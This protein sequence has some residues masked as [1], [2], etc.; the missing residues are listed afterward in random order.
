M[1]A[2]RLLLLS[3]RSEMELA[4]ILSEQGLRR[5][6]AAYGGR[7]IYVPHLGDRGRRSEYREALQILLEEEAQSFLEHFGGS[8]V[9]IPRLSNRNNRRVPDLHRRAIILL[10]QAGFSY[11]QI[12]EICDL[13]LRTIER[14]SSCRGDSS[15]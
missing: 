6:K 2:E 3:A 8:E 15:V 9:P 4:E 1:E 11:P 13:S 14:V 7:L 10:S 12:A 5:L